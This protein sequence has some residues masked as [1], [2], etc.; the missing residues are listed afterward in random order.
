MRAFMIYRSDMPLV[1]DTDEEIQARTG[2]SECFL[3]FESHEI[4]DHVMAE[5]PSLFELDEHDA[6]TLSVREIDI[7]G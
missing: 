2:I 1:W 4:A 5:A 6:E 7:P 3:S